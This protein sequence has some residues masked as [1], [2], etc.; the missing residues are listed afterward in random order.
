MFSC[1]TLFV[2]TGA[3][4]LALVSMNSCP[5]AKEPPTASVPQ[6]LNKFIA[7]REIPGGVALVHEQDRPAE[8]VAVGA[9]D[10]ESATPMTPDTLFGIMSMTKP[11]TATA[12]MILV[13]EGKVSI[14]DPVEKYIPA[15]ADAKTTSGEA[16][17]GLK[18][19][20]LLTH[21]SG[22]GGDQGCDGSL[23]A[24]ANALA[25]RPFDFQP[26]EKWQ[27]GPSMNVVGR[28]VEVASGQPYDEFL[29]ERIFVPLGMNETTFHPTGDARERMATL[30]RKRDGKLGDG[31]DSLVPGERWHGAGEPGCVPNPSG[32]LFS[33]AGDLDR[34]YSMILAGG[35][36]DGKRIVSADAVHQMTTVKTGD[37]ATG[38]TPGNGWGL[39][40]CIVREP[41]DVTGMLSPG[42]FGHGGAYGTQGWVDPVK[43]RIFVLLIQRADLGNADGSD[44]R[45][46]FQQAAV[47]G[48]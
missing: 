3:A 16:V 48:L 40:W 21:T 29:R 46:E 8:T 9:A 1:R 11:M 10:L 17:R 25:E 45:K 12:L 6:V 35:E 43:R 4:W 15:F 41:Q 26:G 7:L 39:G 32:G 19:R 44:L 28:I 34:F 13:D 47:D 31:G 36:L 14:D 5:Y 27:Y 33:T 42:S 38:F 37:L 23:E 22:L 2:L 24:T 20:H 18:I 30:Y